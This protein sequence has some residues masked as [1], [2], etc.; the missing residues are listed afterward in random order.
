MV[1]SKRPTHTIVDQLEVLVLKELVFERE[2]NQSLKASS[3][4]CYHWVF[5]WVNIADFFGRQMVNV[6]LSLLVTFTFRGDVC[7]AKG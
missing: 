2:S 7:I 5:A 3:C 4:S 1:G 6:R